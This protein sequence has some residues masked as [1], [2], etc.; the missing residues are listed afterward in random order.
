MVEKPLYVRVANT[1]DGG[2]LFWRLLSSPSPE[3]GSRS[4]R[5]TRRRPPTSRGTR[6]PPSRSS[7]ATGRR[8]ST[9]RCR[10]SRKARGTSLPTT[11]AS[12][13]TRSWTGSPAVSGRPRARCGSRTTSP[14][15]ARRRGSTG[16]YFADG[17]QHLD[18]DTYQ[19]HQAP[20]TTSDFAF[21]GALRD[22]A[23]AVWRGMIRVEEGAQKTNAYQENRN[24]LLLEERPTPTRSP[25]SRSSPTTC[26]ART[27]RPSGRSIASSCSTSCP[28]VSR[29]RRPS[30]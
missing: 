4:S 7:S 25:V 12:T 22:R 18:Y 10:V 17:D 5:S 6:T 13:A 23:R 15:R 20:H 8:W 26:A 9:S 24:L 27:A 29:A 3:A 14:A 1:V 28:A 16:A 30:G 11:R 21:K 2:S 19:L